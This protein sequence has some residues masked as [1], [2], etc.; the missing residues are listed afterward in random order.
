MGLGCPDGFRSGQDPILTWTCRDNL[1]LTWKRPKTWNVQV[2]F[3][4]D[5]FYQTC[6]ELPVKRGV[7]HRMTWTWN[8]GSG[9]HVVIQVRIRL[10]YFQTE[11][12]LKK[13]VKP[14]FDPGRPIPILKKQLRMVPHLTEKSIVRINKT[15]TP[16]C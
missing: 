7:Q 6:F 13:W 1:D 16:S 12:D 5:L 3:Q 14:F 10:I 2:Q 4:V 9:Q 8:S 15:T 11:P